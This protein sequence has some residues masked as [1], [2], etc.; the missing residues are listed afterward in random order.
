MLPP[1]STLWHRLDA[2]LRRLRPHR[3]P[4][5]LALDALVIAACW[6][7]TYLF[8]LGFERWWSARPGYDGWVLLGIVALY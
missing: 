5:A 6:N 1:D 3:Q 8:R 4:L 7:F 2:A